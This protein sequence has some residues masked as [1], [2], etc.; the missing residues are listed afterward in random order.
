MDTNP[1]TQGDELLGAS[2]RLV[3]GRLARQLRRHTVGGLTP[4]EYSALATLDRHG[5]VRPSDLSELEGVSAPTLSRIVARLE[6]RGC[7]TRE[8][9]SADRRSCLMAIS[10]RGRETLSAV[11]RERTALLALSLGYL[12]EQERAALAAAMPALDQLAEAVR[13]GAALAVAGPAA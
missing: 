12:D 13:Q 10:D 8:G 9:N 6:Q 2:L 3:I 1:A 5:P 11:R 7:V 4:S